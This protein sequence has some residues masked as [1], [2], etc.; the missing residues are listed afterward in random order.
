M[1]VPT[2]L[3]YIVII[4]IA[5]A[6]FLSGYYISEYYSREQLSIKVSEL[7]ELKK[8]NSELRSTIESLKDRILELE[9]MK[10]SLN[11]QLEQLDKE[12][13]HLISKLQDKDR[14]ITRL[15]Y[16]CVTCSKDLSELRNRL[17]SNRDVIERLKNDRELL[18]IL[19]TEPPL[20][21]TQAKI[22]WN[23][24]R[25]GLY[26][27][28]PNL[29]FTIDTIINYL[30]Y[31]FDW[32]ESLPRDSTPEQFCNWI[33]SYTPEADAYASAISKLRNEI[34]VIIISDLGEALR[35]LEEST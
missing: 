16:S 1:K 9:S 18:L 29:V 21:R 11:T 23:D 25:S 3:I 35:I 33:F 32:Y 15:N 7:E 2:Y 27:L 5:V 14:E 4:I 12:L 22:Y 13:S 31:Y 24:T 10:I 19:K 28:N 34:Y 26:K 30:D 20:N 17:I 6:S 8:K